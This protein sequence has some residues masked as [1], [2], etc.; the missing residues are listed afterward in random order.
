MSRSTEPS[1]WYVAASPAISRVALAGIAGSLPYLA[2][3]L[4]WTWGGTVGSPG[5]LADQF[6]KNGAPEFL[7]WL[8]RHGIDFT[9]VGTV[10]GITLLGALTRPW[11]QT[12]PRWVPLLHGKR[13]PRWIPLTPGWATAL[14]LAPYGTMGVTELIFGNLNEENLAGM[15]K[16]VYVIGFVGFFSLGVSIAVCTVAYQRR[17]RHARALAR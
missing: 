16:G 13:V 14:T 8:E 12:F 10:L 3:K 2:M 11:G 7:V 15:P 9:A 4:Y 5:N 1:P 6:R 17:T